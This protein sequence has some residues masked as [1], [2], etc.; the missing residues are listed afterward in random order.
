MTVTLEPQ[1]DKIAQTLLNDAFAHPPVSGARTVAGLVYRGRLVCRGRNLKK[2][3]PLQARFCRNPDAIFFHAEINCIVEAE[4]QDITIAGLQM[5]VV[6][7]LSDG[8]PGLAKPCSGC[9][10]ALHYFGVSEAIYSDYSGLQR[11]GVADG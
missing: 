11:I 1:I 7:A 3:H 5:Y 8:S 10:G 4:K 6:R 2:T 9:M